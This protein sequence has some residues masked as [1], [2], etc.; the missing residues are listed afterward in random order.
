M[1]IRTVR[2]PKVFIPEFNG[3][4]DLPENEQIKVNIK[5]FPTAT[6]SGSY[7]N[8]RQ[9]LDGAIEL[10]YSNDATMLVRHIGGIS[11]IEP[12]ENS[13]GEIEKINNGSSL[14]KTKVLELNPL[15]SEIR[16][17]LL[18]ASSPLDE[19]ESEASE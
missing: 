7:K 18:D 2:K 4:K 14:A 15:I 1:K 10:A 13:E 16:E 8:F 19:G 11:N 9:T 5:S 3:N 6:E 17:Y 12:I